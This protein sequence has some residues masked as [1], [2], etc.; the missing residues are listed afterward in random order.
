MLVVAGAVVLAACTTPPAPGVP[1]PQIGPRTSWGFPDP[2]LLESG[3]TWHA[4]AT[5]WT[6]GSIMNVPYMHSDDLVHWSFPADAMPALGAWAVPG[7]TWGP[8][9]LKHNGSYVLYY[10]ATKASSGKR[11]VATATAG[12]PAGPFVDR[13]PLVC[14][15]KR[16]GTND[17]NVFRAGDGRLFLHWKTEGVIFQEPTRI[18]AQQLANNGL[19]PVEGTRRRVLETA[20]PWEGNVIENPAMSQ[21]DGS[22]WLFYSANE[23]NSAHYGV[24]VA[25]CS[26]PLGPCQRVWSGPLLASSWNLAGPG[27]A[28]VTIDG[29]G[30]PLLAY[31]SWEP[32][33]IGYD[34]G[35]ERRL[36]FSYW[37]T[38][39][40]GVYLG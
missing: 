2:F 25:R 20:M 16:G 34:V 38:S 4:Y 36:F 37:H 26:S 21:H 1:G 7:E 22:Y 29:S 17:P 19:A 9:V 6:G 31:H 15:S 13:G 5:N 28:S 30:R 33:K 32:G 27:G 11:C 18:Y 39:G 23:W 40:G 8:S 24:G 12:G 3:G 10:S 35:G 14:Q